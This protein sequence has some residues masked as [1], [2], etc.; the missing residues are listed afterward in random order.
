MHTDSVFKRL[1]CRVSALIINAALTMKLRMINTVV[2][3]RRLDH[4]LEI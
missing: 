4:G 2:T 3:T 1:N